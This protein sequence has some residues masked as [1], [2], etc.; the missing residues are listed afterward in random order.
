M[1]QHTQTL[2]KRIN[3]LLTVNHILVNVVGDSSVEQHQNK[4]RCYCPIHGEKLFRTLTIDIDD[5]TF[6]CSYTMCRGFRGG[7]LLTLY[8]LVT[9]TPLDEALK[10]WA[11]E[12]G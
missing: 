3:N 6:K 1:E 10:Y 7:D 4:I 5:R 11:N 8:S 9:N 2:R 12:L